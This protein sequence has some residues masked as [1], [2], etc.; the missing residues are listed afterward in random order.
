MAPAR[1]PARALLL[2]YASLLAA[3]VGLGSPEPGAPSGNR[4][5]EE[6]P[7][8]NELPAGPA[9]HPPVRGHPACPGPGDLGP[10]PPRPQRA[11]LGPQAPRGRSAL[12]SVAAG[13]GAS[14]ARG[15]RG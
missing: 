14:R 3:A 15:G 9:A 5:R 2:A 1:C 10:Q 6:P 7:P 8:G 11:P 12:A 13:S 4:A